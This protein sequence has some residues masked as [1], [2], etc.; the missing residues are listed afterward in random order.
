MQPLCIGVTLCR[1]CLVWLQGVLLQLEAILRHNVDPSAVPTV[2]A[3]VG[4]HLVASSGACGPGGCVKPAT[5]AVGGFRLGAAQLG[6]AIRPP[7]SAI[8]F[9]WVHAAHAAL[10]LL[11]PNLCATAG[12]LI[13]CVSQ[14]C[15]QAAH[16][17]TQLCGE[18]SRAGRAV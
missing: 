6:G 8:S 4:P 1:C 3:L 17:H 13:A 2:L 5:G 15:E 7:P 18:Y 10:A 14:Q 12:Q 11:P 9:A 16:K